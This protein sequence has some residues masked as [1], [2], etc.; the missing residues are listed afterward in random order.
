MQ[1]LHTEL[2][3]KDVYDKKRLHSTIGYRFLIDFEKEVR[4][5]EVLSF[6]YCFL[7]LTS[8]I[9]TREHLNFK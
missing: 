7:T 8:C 9:L 6:K 2:A 4:T 5:S 3:L 1:S